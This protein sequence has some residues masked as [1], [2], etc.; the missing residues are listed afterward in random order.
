MTRL[1]DINISILVGREGQK[2][3][4][5]TPGSESIR[6]NSKNQKPFRITRNGVRQPGSNFSLGRKGFTTTATLSRV[7]IGDLE[8]AAGQTVTEVHV[9]APEVLQAESVY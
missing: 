8:S 3:F 2:H 5:T 9:R 6:R 4:S 7:G 1:V